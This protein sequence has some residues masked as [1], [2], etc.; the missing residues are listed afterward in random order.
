MVETRPAT[1]VDAVMLAPRLRRADA[2]EIASVLSVPPVEGLLTCLLRSDRAFSLVA[3]DEVIGL[4]GVSELRFGGL[5]LG[6]PWMLG[7]DALFFRRRELA[8][9]SR[10]WVDRLL[11]GYDVLT[12]LTAAANHAHLRWLAWCGFRPLRVHRAYGAAASP[13][14][15]FYRVNRMRQPCDRGVRETLLARNL[16]DVRRDGAGLL[17]A[18]GIAARAFASTDGVDPA[19]VA[20]L[21]EL[22]QHEPDGERATSPGVLRLAIDLARGLMRRSEG[23]RPADGAVT[24]WCRHVVSVAESCSLEPGGDP[25]EIMRALGRVPLGPV[26]SATS[27]IDDR[28][29]PSGGP[30]RDDIRPAFLAGRLVA[31]LTLGGRVSRVQGRL[32]RMAALGIGPV[33]DV[34]AAGIARPDLAALWARRAAPHRGAAPDADH[35]G[36]ACRLWA[37]AGGRD[38]LAA[39]LRRALEALPHTRLTGSSPDI[40]AAAG[41][42]ADRMSRAWYP[43]IRLAGVSTGYAERQGLYWLLRAWLWVVVTGSTTVAASVLAEDVAALLLVADVEAGMLRR[44]GPEVTR[45]DL[46]DVVDGL[47]RLFHGRLVEPED[48]W[49][50]RQHVLPVAVL[51]TVHVAQLQPALVAWYVTLSGRLRATLVELVAASPGSGGSESKFRAAWREAIGRIEAARVR[52]WLIEGSVDRVR[53]G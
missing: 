2:E 48:R 37:E 4:W 5:K 50:W 40:L 32:L 19:S 46:A 8:R 3:D 22:L 27:Q 9:H 47:D 33:E 30:D 44:D 51:P 52:P 26:S 13:F 14:C 53:A 12:N 10:A 25:S 1:Y 38:E 49:F 23:G 6:V 11:L 20:D 24:G 39:G 18:A 29:P 36:S 43:G 34:E 31:G 16:P 7:A 42:M 45:D 21:I 28:P 17:E 35:L 41:T 15:E